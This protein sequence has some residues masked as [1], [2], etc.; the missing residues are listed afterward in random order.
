MCL[1]AY[2]ASFLSCMVVD[3]LQSKGLLWNASREAASTK[4]VFHAHEHHCRVRWQA[5]LHTLCLVC[6]VSK[7]H[8]SQHRSRTRGAYSCSS[9]TARS[10]LQ[11]L[12]ESGQHGGS[13]HNSGWPY[14]A[15]KAATVFIKQSTLQQDGSLVQACSRCRMQTKHCG[16]VQECVGLQDQPA[17]CPLPGSP[18]RGTQTPPV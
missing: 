2:A 14:G 18:A 3:V 13:A 17:A 1:K 10:A 8:R 9:Y 4:Q 12:L 15:G 11:T 7:V 6:V 16:H 5:C